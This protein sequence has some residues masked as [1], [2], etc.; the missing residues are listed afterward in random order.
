MSTRV[1]PPTDNPPSNCSDA[2]F[3]VWAA[4]FRKR[5]SAELAQQGTAPERIAQIVDYDIAAARRRSQPL[6]SEVPV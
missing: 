2:D 6:K 4:G 1:E 5:R 3:A